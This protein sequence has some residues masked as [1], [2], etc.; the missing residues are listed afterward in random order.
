MVN[1]LKK[2]WLPVKATSYPNG[3]WKL[4]DFKSMWNLAEVN[5][6]QFIYN[7]V[8]Q[9]MIELHW[10]LFVYIQNTMFVGCKVKT[11]RHGVCN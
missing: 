11:K 9:R 4:L 2:H 7:E 8:E 5:K 6:N 3:R 10:L 1:S